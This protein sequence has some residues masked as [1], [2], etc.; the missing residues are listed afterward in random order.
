MLVIEHCNRLGWSKEFAF[1]SS[2]AMNYTGI[3]TYKTYIKAL[4]DLIEFGFIRMV[5]KTRNQLI[6]TPTTILSKF[7][8]SLP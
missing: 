2:Y 7:F 4:N 1:P 6:H 8:M 3:A 5:K